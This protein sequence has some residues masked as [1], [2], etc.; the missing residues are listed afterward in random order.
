MIVQESAQGMTQATGSEKVP[1]T[2]TTPTA[3]DRISTRNVHRPE[4]R[5]WSHNTFRPKY[6]RYLKAAR[7][8]V[9]YI[10]RLRDF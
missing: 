4:L 3:N 9:G 1:T 5:F 8:E 10:N 6:I 7:G 2:P